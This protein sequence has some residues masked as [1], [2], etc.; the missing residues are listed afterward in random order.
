MYI[1]VH[2]KADAKKASFEKISENEFK[3]TVQE[4]AIMNAANKRVLEV[5]REQY[6]PNAMQ[7]K[8]ISGHH[9]PVKLLRV[10]AREE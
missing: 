2:V 9:A 7:I 10:V 5:F 1:R 8:I 3:I 4:K 6:F